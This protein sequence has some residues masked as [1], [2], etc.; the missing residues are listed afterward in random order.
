MPIGIGDDAIL[1]EAGIIKKIKKQKSKTK[2]S[3]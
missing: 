2:K 1:V 3:G